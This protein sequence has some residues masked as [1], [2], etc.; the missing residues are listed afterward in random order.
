MVYNIGVEE[1]ESYCAEGAI[2]H[3]CQPFSAAGRHKGTKDERHLWPEF[4]RLIKE[5]NP[6]LVFGEQVASKDG[7]LW[8]GNVRK[9]LIGIGY[10]FGAADLC[11]A[12]VGAP[13]IRQRLYFAA[14]RKA[15]GCGIPV[16]LA[17][18]KQ[19]TGTHT[20]CEAEGATEESPLLTDARF[21]SGKN[22]KRV[23]RVNGDAAQSRSG[24]GVGQPVTGSDQSQ[25]GLYGKKHKGNLLRAQL[26]IGNVGS[27]NSEESYFSDDKNRTPIQEKLA[28][29]FK[30]TIA[31]EASLE[32]QL[33]WKNWTISEELQ[34]P[35]IRASARTEKSG[36]IMVRGWPTPDA[37]VMN[38]GESLE[39]FQARQ[40]TLKNKT[41]MKAD[42]R[43]EERMQYNSREGDNYQAI[44]LQVVTQISGWPTAGASDGSGT[45]TSS[46]PLA[47]IRP[48]G[49]K[50]SLTLNEAAQIS[51]LDSTSSP[52]S[53]TKRGALNPAHSRWLMGLPKEWDE[54]AIRAIRL[55]PKRRPKRG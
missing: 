32:Y 10:E 53:I 54:A 26:R 1:D 2:V 55:T 13:H 6:P 47:R 17:K 29:Q 34:I 18:N 7:R 37:S 30:T 36:L 35:A 8:L 25:S 49:T 27:G 44:S 22:S 5:C 42:P 9:D 38:D 4:Y 3:N 51:G 12:A 31:T 19:S 20:S 50:K 23:L 24:K 11:A 28:E 14:R 52:V 45:R 46:N 40:A 39:S 41:W 21:R 43:A 48:S 15:K 16:T 33:K